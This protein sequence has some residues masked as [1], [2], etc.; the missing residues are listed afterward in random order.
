MAGDLFEDAE[1]TE[2]FAEVEEE[3]DFDEAPAEVARKG[4]AP[5]QSRLVGRVVLRNEKR[6]VIEILVRG[7]PLDWALPATVQVQTATGLVTLEVRGAGSTRSGR[8]VDGQQ[9]RL[10]LAPLPGEAVVLSLRC[11]VGG[12]DYV[13]EIERG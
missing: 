10:V 7:G 13:V 5:A 1:E 12:A 2:A 4:R 6:L 8:M 11:T 9:L 3:L